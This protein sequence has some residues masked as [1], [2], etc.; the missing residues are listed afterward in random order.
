MRILDIDLDFF[1]EGVA[2]WRTSD[3]GRLD[4]EEYSPWLAADALSFLE[5][6][7]LLNGPLPG[8]ALE[9][10]REL[11]FR[12]R[13][14]VEREALA[15]P[16]H[17]THVDAHADLGLGEISY[18]YLMTSL[19]FEAPEDRVRPKEGQAGLDDGS[20]LAFSI[21]CR[22]I[23]DLVYVFNEGGGQDVFGFFREGFDPT[24]NFIQLAAMTRAEMEMVA[25]L[26]GRPRETRP[27]RL[28]PRVPFAEVPWRDFQA[29]APFDLIFLTRS[30]A[31][32]PPQSDV[33]FDEIRGQFIDER[34]GGQLLGMA[35]R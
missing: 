20:F 1:V 10:H 9:H 33:L 16:F 14:G 6:R 5:Q 15:T 2:H 19:L 25:G 12:W 8:L 24:A 26:R 3:S 11:F 13:D 18:Q 4:G 32:T 21:A 23:S 29:D 7:C 30:P 17:V 34:A 35:A 22:W 31:F 28:E 27:Q